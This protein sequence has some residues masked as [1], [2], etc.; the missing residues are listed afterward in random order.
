M[1]DGIA[2]AFKTSGG[3]AII[4]VTELPTENINEGAFYR[5]TAPYLVFNQR[6]QREQDQIC[7]Y[8]DSLPEIGEPVTTTMSN[9]RVY[10]NAADGDAYGYIT[11]EIGSQAGAPAGWYTLTVLAPLFNVVWNGVITDINDDPCDD[12]FRLLLSKDF[13][14]YQDGW[15]KLP[16]AYEKAPKFDIQWDGVIG[17]RFALD[18]SLLGFENTYFVKVSDDVLTVDQLIGATYSLADG[19]TYTIETQSIDSST[20]PGAFSVDSTLVVAYDSDILNTALGLPSGYITNGIYFVL[21]VDLTYT[22]RLVAP[23]RIT[24]IDEK[25]LPNMSVDVD[26]LGLHSVATSGNYNDLWNRPNLNNYVTSSQLNNYV[27]SSQV[28]TKISQAIGNA[29]GGGY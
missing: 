11:A 14:I 19:Y 25:Y 18:M 17:D 5:L 23:R 12:S 7:F 1:E 6:D 22:N 28:D 4:D 26:S 24:K 29:I 13:Y 27:T 15:M 9:L 8:V 20:Y 21:A 2:N 3:S 16:F 10:Y